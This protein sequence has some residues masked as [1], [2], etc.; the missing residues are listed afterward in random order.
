MALKETISNMKKIVMSFVVVIWALSIGGTQTID[1]E[2]D[3]PITNNLFIKLYGGVLHYQP[4]EKGPF[5]E[6]TLD[7]KIV[8]T[9]FGYQ[10]NRKTQFVTELEVEYANNIMVGIIPR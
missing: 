2:N 1:F 3:Q 9:L 6:G 4:F 7:V 5:L 10:F 8:V